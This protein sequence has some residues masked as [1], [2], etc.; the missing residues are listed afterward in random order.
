MTSAHYK[1]ALAVPQLARDQSGESSLVDLV[2]EVAKRELLR[3]LQL[4]QV[5]KAIAECH[6]LKA[7]AAARARIFTE[8]EQTNFE[9]TQSGSIFD[10]TDQH[11]SII[12]LACWESNQVRVREVEG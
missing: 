7:T 11:L 9:A 10:F 3:N 1:T 6:A 2:H 4:I 5:Q 12:L 8:N